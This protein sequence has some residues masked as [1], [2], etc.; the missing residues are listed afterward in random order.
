MAS[1][2]ETLRGGGGG[3]RG[4]LS[5]SSPRPVHESPLNHIPALNENALFIDLRSVKADFS[6][7]EK[8]DFLFK[9]LGCKASEVKSIFPDLST[10][11]R[12]SFKSDEIF[13]RYSARLAT[14]VLWVA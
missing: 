9:D 10:L 6:M 1:Y 8:N 5:L 11:L 12:I 4:R 13:E 3:L 2:A 7:E 14:G